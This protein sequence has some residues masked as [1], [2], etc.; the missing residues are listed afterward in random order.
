MILH[1]RW[2]KVYTTQCMGEQCKRRDG[3]DGFR[4]MNGR[5][6]SG[7]VYKRFQEASKN[8]EQ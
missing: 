5:T 2:V 4:E 3:Y 1:V 8:E 6:F 7:F